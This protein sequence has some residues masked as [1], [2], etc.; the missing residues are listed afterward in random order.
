M[1][2]IVILGAG[3]MGSAFSFPLVDSGHEVHLVGT[4]LDG[5]EIDTIKAHNRH[6]RLEPH[7]LPGVTAFRTESLPEVLG[8]K[9]DLIV[10][11][12]SSAGVDWAI[13]ALFKALP[14]RVPGD[15]PIL[16]LTKGLALNDDGDIEVLP[17]RV[18]RLL[19][20]RGVPGVAV[21]AVGG[22]CIA[23]EVAA[24]RHSGVVI[25]FNDAAV[26]QRV[27][28]LLAADYYHH[29]GTTDLIGL[30]ACAA[31]KNFYALAVGSA[32]SHNPAALLFTRA[33][34]EMAVLVEYFGGTPES[35]YDLAGTGDFYVTC[36]AGRNSRMG[37]F[38]GTG[39]TYNEAKSRHMKDDTVEGAEV[40]ANVGP[41]IVELTRDGR[42]ALDMLPLTVELIEAIC[43]D[44]RLEIPWCRLE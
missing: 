19:E 10:L 8:S 30:E 24:R 40:A 31:M 17:A 36:L 14:G 11:G 38:L 23:A 39:L 22:P 33:I 35:V 32:T 7:I 1:A 37:A 34:R 5:E 21:G 12:V 13:D 26:L 2:K 15:V 41:A 20:S 9:T 29:S 4:H 6:P 3:V 16:M 25:G 28:S 42:I 18:S 27:R 43:G 44:R